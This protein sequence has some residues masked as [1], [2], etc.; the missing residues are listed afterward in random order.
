VTYLEYGWYV[1]SGRRL[2]EP[3]VLSPGRLL[4]LFVVYVNFTLHVNFQ[5]DMSHDLMNKGMELYGS[6]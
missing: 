3:L 1:A 4:L 6:G 5:Q 2:S